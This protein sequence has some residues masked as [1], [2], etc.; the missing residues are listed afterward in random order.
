M[1]CGSPGGSFDA[2]T[3]RQEPLVFSTPAESPCSTS[4]EEASSG[5]AIL[6][7]NFAFYMLKWSGGEMGARMVISMSSLSSKQWLKLVWIPILITCFLPLCYF[8]SLVSQQSHS[9]SSY[10]FK[11]HQVTQF[12]KNKWRCAKTTAGLASIRQ[13]C[14]S[15]S[16]ECFK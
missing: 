2:V 3:L 9:I 10:T 15:G 7:Q 5:A 12:M 16:A 6:G 11:N 13:L 1:C 14:V 4:T 8:L